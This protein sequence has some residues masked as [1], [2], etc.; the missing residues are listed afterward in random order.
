MLDPQLGRWWSVDPLAGPATRWSPYTY[1]YDNPIRFIDPDGM[2]AD[3][4]NG[5][6]ST[7]DA[8]EIRPFCNNCNLATGIKEQIQNLN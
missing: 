6:V 2:W 5:G 8:G 3:D 4:P 1:A 7:S